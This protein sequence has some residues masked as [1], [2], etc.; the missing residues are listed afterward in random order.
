[1]STDS[2]GIAKCLGLQAET[3]VELEDILKQIEL[4]ISM[5]TLMSMEQPPPAPSLIE[6]ALEDES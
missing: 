3:N 6:Q 5:Q 1:L 2:D 4:K